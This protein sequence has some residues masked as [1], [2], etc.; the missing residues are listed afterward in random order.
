M[1]LEQWVTTHKHRLM[2][3]LLDGMCCDRE[4]RARTVLNL[5]GLIDHVLRQMY[6]DVFDATKNHKPAERR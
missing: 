3:M 1:D 2:G 6:A 5:A 4:T